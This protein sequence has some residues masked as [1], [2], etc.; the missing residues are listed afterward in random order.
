MQR[1]YWDAHFHIPR[2]GQEDLSVFLSRCEAEGL[3]HFFAGGYDPADWQRQLTLKLSF[4]GKLKN[5]FGLHPWWIADN[6]DKSKEAIQLLAEM[7]PQADAL[8]E[9]GLDYFYIEKLAGNKGPIDKDYLKALQFELFAEQLEL[10]QKYQK[11]AVLHIVK[12]LE[13]AL[14]AIDET[15]CQVTQT[16]DLLNRDPKVKYRIA[17][18]RYENPPNSTAELATATLKSSKR[19][20]VLGIVHSCPAKREWIYEFQRR[21][22]LVSFGP[23]ILKKSRLELA[24]ALKEVNPARMLVETDFSGE[25][26]GDYD[27]KTLFR[28][29]KA[30]GSALGLS[31][32]E[33]L[34][35]SAQ[36]L[37]SLFSKK[38]IQ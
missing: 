21:G 11:P 5:S 25:G 17:P 1:S 28:V 9:C 24:A 18:E 26:L 16:C 38:S 27:P 23:S 2:R 33:V 22:L 14:K 30:A 20:D 29:A 12:A 3:T 35:Y 34:G 7:L 8:G 4:Q 13:P 32:E 15:K 6:P 36:A 19:N 31:E 37:E 10:A